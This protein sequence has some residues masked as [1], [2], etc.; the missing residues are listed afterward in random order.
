MELNK[1]ILDKENSTI[2]FKLISEE[3]YLW[4][5][6]ISVVAKRNLVNKRTNVISNIKLAAELK[7]TVIQDQQAHFIDDRKLKFPIYLFP[8]LRQIQPEI[9][10]NR[11]IKNQPFQIGINPDLNYY[12]ILKLELENIEELD[13]NLALLFN[14]EKFEIND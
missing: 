4:I 5:K 12:Q 1:F 11:F 13:S 3:S 6:S 14:V 8:D 7:Y 10:I 9:K 2:E